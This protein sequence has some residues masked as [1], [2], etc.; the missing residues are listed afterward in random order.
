M[1]LWEISNKQSELIDS[2]DPN[3]V[4]AVFERLHE[5]GSTAGQ[6]I[7]CLYRNPLKDL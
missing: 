6:A 4:P 3:S 1:T 7:P 2:L 5:M